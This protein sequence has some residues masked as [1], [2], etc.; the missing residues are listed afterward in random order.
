[1]I[2]KSVR[3][4][5]LL[6]AIAALIIGAAP[7]SAHPL[8]IG[9]EPVTIA[10]GQLDGTVGLAP[11]PCHD[12]AYN[13]IGAKWANG[14]YDWSFR[15]RSVPGALGRRAAR[16]TIIKAFHNITSEHNDCG[17]ATHT[18]ISADYLG[19][20]GRRVNCSSR[21]GHNVIGFGR[22]PRGI[23]AV[24]CYWTRNGRMV[25]ADMTI[26][27]RESW[28]LSL[29][30]C[31]NQVMLE[32]TITHEAGHVFGLAHV[33]ERRHGRLTMSPYIDGPCENNEASLGLGDMLGLEALY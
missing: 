5:A 12:S 16:D 2:T 33:S 11:N 29:T 22:L 17:R 14:T 27:S 20:T 6:A 30:N 19:N 32:S 3:L 21:D 1:M 8:Q 28:A 9:R 24:T 18:S 31:H 7:T 26:N 23:L 4:A 25:E 15:A 10:A 13:L